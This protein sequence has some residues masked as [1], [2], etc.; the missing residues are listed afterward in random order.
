MMTDYELIMIVCLLCIVFRLL[1]MFL[2]QSCV[3]Q[4]AL[5]C[6]EHEPLGMW[7]PFM[8]LKSTKR[9]SFSLRT[10]VM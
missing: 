1:M 3:A 10:W 7:Y 9:R 5:V 6:T 8:G 4:G 2:A